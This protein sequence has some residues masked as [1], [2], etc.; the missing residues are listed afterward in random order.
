M[1]SRC[2]VTDHQTK[3]AIL[4]RRRVRLMVEILTRQR[5]EVTWLVMIV[6]LAVVRAI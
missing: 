1:Y 2:V 3:N 5:I 4:T 6:L